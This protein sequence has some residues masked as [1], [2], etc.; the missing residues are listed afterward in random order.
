MHFFHPRNLGVKW[1]RKRERKTG[2]WKKIV[3]RAWHMP[4]DYFPF[5]SFPFLTLV[6]TS[7]IPLNVLHTHSFTH[8][9]LFSS[10]FLPIFI[11]SITLLTP[12]FHP[13]TSL[14]S[15]EHGLQNQVSSSSS[16][17][18]FLRSCKKKKKHA[19]YLYHLRDFVSI[20]F[21]FET[22]FVMGRS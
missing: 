14:E 18:S 4:V 22:Y 6:P 20:V 16:S 21:A 12:M 1:R 10:C 19:H 15:I 9:N 5:L 7:Y 13:R 17:S 11:N 3:K 8:F 2:V